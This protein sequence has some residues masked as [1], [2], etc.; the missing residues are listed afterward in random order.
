MG[1]PLGEVGLRMHFFAA[2]ALATLNLLLGYFVLPETVTDHTRRPFD[3]K[4]A[5]PLGALTQI[6]LIPGLSQFLLVFFSMSSPF[7]SIPRF[8]SITLKGNLVGIRT[9]LAC[10]SPPL[11]SRFSWLR[12]S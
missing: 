10:L 1:G 2:A 3:I 8:G 6:R 11:N 9:C 5:N 7:T 12:V 4:R